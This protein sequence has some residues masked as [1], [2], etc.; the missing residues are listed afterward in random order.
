MTTPEK[1]F[2]AMKDMIKEGRPSW[3]QLAL[4]CDDDPDVNVEEVI[5]WL[6]DIDEG[7]EI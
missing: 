6:S 5:S 1:F 4:M 2:D 7:K 3:Q